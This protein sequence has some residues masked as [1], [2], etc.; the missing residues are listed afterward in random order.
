MKWGQKEANSHTHQC[1]WYGRCVCIVY[2]VWT[3]CIYVVC[4]H[5]CVWWVVYV[6]CVCCM[7]VFL[8]IWVVYI[9]E[10]CVYMYVMYI[11]MY[12]S[13]CNIYVCVDVYTSIHVYMCS[14]PF[15]WGLRN[16]E[17]LVV[18]AEGPGCWAAAGSCPLFTPRSLAQLS[19]AVP[20]E[21]PGQCSLSH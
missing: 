14:P 3:V 2:V 10:W 4:V 1:V 21:K 18:E 8:H 15:F 13:M 6:W 16:R 9:C 5:V 17:E 12:V 11:C 19:S 7:H 20:T